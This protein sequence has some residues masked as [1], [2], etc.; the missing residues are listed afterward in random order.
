M[1]ITNFFNK[2]RLSE[3]T[4]I[5]EMKHTKGDWNQYDFL[6]ATK[7]YGWDYMLDSAEYLAR[8]DLHGLQTVSFSPMPGSGEELIEEYKTYGSFL[9]MPSLREE[10]SSLGIGGLS[11]TFRG[12]PVKVVWFN[13]T[14]VIRI[15]TLLD[16]EEL[17]NRYM[18]TIIRRTFNTEDAMKKARPLN[19]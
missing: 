3:T 19:K 5:A 1:K 10:G 14:R 13:Q 18:E 12:Q 8:A 11:Q 4:Y 9:K 15:F 7:G 2:N 6:L 16:D 17:L